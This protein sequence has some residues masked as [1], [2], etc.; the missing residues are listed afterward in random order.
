MAKSIKLTKRQK[1]ILFSIIEEYIKTAKP[2]ASELLSQKFNLSSALLRNEMSF[3]NKHGYLFKI[4]AS[5]GRIPTDKALRLFINDISIN[6]QNE[7][8]D[9][10]KYHN[11]F[12][13]LLNCL[14]KEEDIFYSISYGLSILSKHFVVSGIVEEQKFFKY[15]LRNLFIQPEFKISK[16]LDVVSEVIDN[17]DNEIKRITRYCNQ[18]INVFIG[19]EIPFNKNMKDFSLVA[20][21]RNYKKK[22]NA[23]V[24]L[25]GPKRM[26]YKKN[27]YLINSIDSFLSR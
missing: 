22:K 14:E 2:V 5:S 27:L 25:L 24:A 19:K 15:G 17:I 20:I 16:N 8:N 9:S 11:H 21:K 10:S 7:I 4:H 23:I 3:L 12:L 18:F 13:K 6:L 26:D 1:S